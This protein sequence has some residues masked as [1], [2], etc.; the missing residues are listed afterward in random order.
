M[1]KEIALLLADAITS[2][3]YQRT[4]GINRSV[5][6]MTGENSF[7][8]GGVLINL[9]AQS[10]PKLAAKETDP[11]SFMG[12]NHSLPEAVMKWADIERF[13]MSTRDGKP[14]GLKKYV[15]MN[16]LLQPDG[17][18]SLN[19]PFSLHH[20]ND[21][22][23]PRAPPRRAGPRALVDRARPFVYSWEEIAAWLRTGENHTRI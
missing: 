5:S 18:F 21:A 9:F 1:K 15:D 22:L 10:H 11:L 14:L 12:T 7:C 23:A 16:G 19:S 20:A 6:H 8:L 3:H 13:D 2:G 17:L 4:H